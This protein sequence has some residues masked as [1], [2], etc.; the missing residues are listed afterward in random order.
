MNI[1]GQQA[2]VWGIW[3]L[4]IAYGVLQATAW[5]ISGIPFGPLVALELSAGWIVMI[6]LALLATRGLGRLSQTLEEAEHAHRVKSTEV[7]QL[8]MQSAMLDIIARSVDVPLAFQELAHRIAR[9]VPCERVGLAL[10]SNDNTEFQ[11]YT[12]RVQ[13]R[14]R[15]SRPRP[16]V[17]FKADRTVIGAVV[18]SREP[19]IINDTEKVMADY[20]DVNV[21][22]TSGFGSGL[23]LPLISKGRGVGTLNVVSRTTGAFNQQ[24]IDALVP[25]AEI[26]AVAH[27]AQQLQL[28]LAR[29]RTAES[30][31]EL[32][33]GIA[34]E[35]NG[36]LQTII[37][38][39]ALLEREY[40]DL[41]L[42]ADLAI[43]VRQSQRIAAL[44]EKM[45][46]DSHERLRR[47]DEQVGLGAVETGAAVESGS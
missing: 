25:V 10:L 15:R 1:R 9:L 47:L 38:H 11:T 2:A 8:Q 17:V 19:M 29:H 43:V 5:T 46:A 33:L 45:R 13:D 42:T 34:S 36:A 39:C 27:V 22:R 32:T 23:V 21:L 12:A 35:I 3:G 31:S 30:M 6:L 20:L 40:P 18:K 16:E 4:L 41:N 14:E 26:L 37:G 7:E 44:L 24:H 28:G